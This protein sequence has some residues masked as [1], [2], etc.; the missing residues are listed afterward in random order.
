[1]PLV[2]AAAWS[3]A[4]D[5]SPHERRRF[6]R[7]QIEVSGRLRDPRG[8]EFDCRTL[9]VSPGDALIVTGASLS[10]G[11]DILI[12][13]AGLGRIEADVMRALPRDAAYG[14]RFRITRHKLERHVETLTGLLFPW[15]QEADGRRF[16][17]ESGQGDVD[18]RLADGRQ[19][20]CSVVDIS[21]VGIGLT[22]KGLVR[23]A[24]GEWVTV[25]NKYGRVARYFEGG[26]AIDLSPPA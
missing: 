4:P 23:P 1:M 26:F 6:R 11:D 5:A 8:V 12:Y 24:L 13:L 14:V 21:V 20:A 17:R 9:D 19:I 10:V 3:R 15:A 18:V 22:T 2:R 7:V 16:P 25:G